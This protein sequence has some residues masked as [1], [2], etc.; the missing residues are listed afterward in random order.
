MVRRSAPRR[1]AVTSAIQLT[2]GVAAALTLLL[3][4]DALAALLSAQ[5]SGATLGD[6]VPHLAPL[7]LVVAYRRISEPVLANEVTL[8]GYQVSRTADDQVIDVATVVDYEA[9]EDPAFLN[10]LERSTNNSG[11][12][13][14][15]VQG[16]MAMAGSG[17]ALVGLAW[18]MFALQP[19][20]LPCLAVGASPLWLTSV[21]NVRDSFAT[22]M[23]MVESTRRRR[24]LRGI[25]T[26]RDEAK[27]LRAF[28]LAD[29]VR[30][31]YDRVYDEW[32]EERRRLLRR[33]LRRT[34]R[35]VATGW[36]L[37][38]VFG[39]L[40]LLLFL[41]SRIG[42]AEA[43]AAAFGARLLRNR[44]VTLIS[45]VAR[46]YEAG[47]YLDDLHSFVLLKPAIE[48][49]RPTGKVDAPFTQLVVDKVSFAYPGT[50]RTVL[51]DV[52]LEIRRGEVIAL[53]GENG[54]GKTTLAKLLC[55]LY[56]P[57]SGRVLWDGVDTATV[58]PGSMRDSIAVVFQD[59]VRYELDAH[60][61]VGLG[62]PDRLE[63]W[64][65]VVEASRSAG[66]HEFL[67]ALP[68]GYD[69]LLSR[70]FAGGEDLSIGQW[71][72]VALARAFFRDAAFLV[73]DE[74]TAALD[75]KAE[76]DLFES[77]R[78]LC[79]GRTVLLISHRLSSVR[80][81]DRIYVLDAGEIVE[82]GSHD[83]L[84]AAG[85]LYARLFTLQA[86]AYA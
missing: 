21:R 11:R 5:S 45:G 79:Q 35:G 72:R 23:R 64:E 80:S 38:I 50:E 82:Q 29:S 84:M 49:A 51:R 66:A 53:V 33:G 41:D 6:I 4:R 69:T 19:L 12:A 58:D 14:D 36:L 65:A 27:E 52:S 73:L 1:F 67:A 43:A 39:S 24:Y 22:D 48:A 7:A 75:A 40:L 34:L 86:A 56:R 46:L 63:D 60:S 2:A 18:A 13:M 70:A 8:L 31:R 16:L 28:G 32:I 83:D 26:G 3:G 59:F 74:P 71:Q 42:L 62:R 37:S 30:Q 55:Q 61:N 47:L 57:Q 81:A 17:F 77:V 44:V 9:F 20:L 68:Q 10:Q 85:R 15:I 76:H 54:C 78:R 25:L